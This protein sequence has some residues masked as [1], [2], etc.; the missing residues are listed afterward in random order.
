MNN[1][2]SSFKSPKGLAKYMAAYEAG[3]QLWPLAYET[4]DIPGRFGCTHLVASGPKNAP[5]MVLLHGYFATSTMWAE[6]I[7][8]FSRDYRVY[9]LD[10]M[11]QPGKSIPDQPIRSREDFV[12][13][14][15]SILDALKID[16]VTLV[17]MSYGG[18][19]TLNYA[20]AAPERL[21]KIV[22]LSPAASFLPLVQQFNL[23]AMAMI[24]LSSRFVVN[25]FMG[26]MTYKENLKNPHLL[27]TYNN[28]VD[29][30]Y[31]GL[32]H[33]RMQAGVRPEVYS[34]EELQGLQVPVLLL[35]GKQE[36]IYDPSASIERAVRLIPRVEA[37]LIPNASHDMSFSQARLVDEHIL[38][39]L[40]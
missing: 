17:G 31:L 32:R 18:W 6:N 24:L 36:V 37:A 7:A 33:Y 2:P 4:M 5:P 26:W 27:K 16:R 9:A 34:D 10:V 20:I 11:G 1:L 13:W 22:L 21:N 40:G 8:D 14:L 23:G 28:M 29:Q 12:E 39:F 15:T 30:M 3:T 19:L 38:K 25:R 35:I